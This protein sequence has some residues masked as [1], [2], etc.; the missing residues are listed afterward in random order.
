M[1]WKPED[2]LEDRTLDSVITAAKNSDFS[3]FKCVHLN[4]SGYT[5]KAFP[6]GIPASILG[7]YRRHTSPMLGQKNKI[8][9]EEKSEKPS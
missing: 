4:K 1:D 9:F 8:V 7:G 3:C 6:E 5:C 2:D